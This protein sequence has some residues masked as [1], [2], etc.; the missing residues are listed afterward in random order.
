MSGISGIGGLMSVAFQGMLQTQESKDK[1]DDQA[2]ES[3]ASTQSS[4]P[5]RNGQEDLGAL[6]DLMG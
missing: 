6:L 1:G 2:A 5:S 4:L 3:T